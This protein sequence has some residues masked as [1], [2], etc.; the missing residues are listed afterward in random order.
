MENGN[1]NKKNNKLEYFKEEN[2]IYINSPDKKIIVEEVYFNNI[3]LQ[4]NS[5][6]S[7]LNNQRYKKKNYKYQNNN[8]KTIISLGS[9]STEI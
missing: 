2:E 3:V 5:Q 7:G 6:Q 1:L 4:E 9:G 8:Y